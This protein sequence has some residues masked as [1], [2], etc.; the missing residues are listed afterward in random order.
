MFLFQ[1]SSG[2][3]PEYKDHFCSDKIVDIIAMNYFL[4]QFHHLT[5]QNLFILFYCTFLVTI[6]SLS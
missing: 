3:Y 5:D 2:E 4:N 1:V 6:S